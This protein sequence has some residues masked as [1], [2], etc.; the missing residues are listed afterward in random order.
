MFRNSR[1]RERE[2]IARA[3][4]VWF[5]ADPS[6]ARAARTLVL[7]KA[8]GDSFLKRPAQRSVPEGRVTLSAAVRDNYLGKRD[9]REV[10]FESK[11]K[12]ERERERVEPQDQF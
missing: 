12:R 11:A 8:P 4:L 10:R 9:A 6:A 5:R 7:R 1:E 2:S 3:R